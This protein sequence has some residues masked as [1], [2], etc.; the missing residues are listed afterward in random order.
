LYT[1]CS[2]DGIEACKK[3]RET[4]KLPIIIL[5]AKGQELDKITGLRVGADDYVTKPFSPLELAARIKSQL[6]RTRNYLVDLSFSKAIIHSWYTF[7]KSEKKLKLI[8]ENHSIQRR[9][10][11]LA[12]N[13]KKEV[14]LVEL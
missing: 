3:I 13:W 6:R 2:T 7:E 8:R 12:T 10:G 4:Q 1:S 11:A 5:S 14:L 9:Y